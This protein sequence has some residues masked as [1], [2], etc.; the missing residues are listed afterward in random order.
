MSG[1]LPRIEELSRNA[2][3]PPTESATRVRATVVGLTEREAMKLEP[4][5]EYAVEQLRNAR[6]GPPA[7]PTG[8]EP[9]EVKTP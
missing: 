3:G 9:L 4:P 6:N 5:I 1:D 7:G 2:S 8:K